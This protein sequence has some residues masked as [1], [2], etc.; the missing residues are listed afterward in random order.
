VINSGATM[1]RRRPR[2]LAVG[3]VILF[4]SAVAG[5]RGAQMSPSATAMCKFADGKTITIEYSSPQVRGRQ[6]FGGLVPYGMPWIL[7]ANQATSFVST[8]GVTMGG[9]RVPAG[10][11]SLFAIPQPDAWALIV[12]KTP[13]ENI[14][15]MSYY[16]GADSDLLRVP[17]TVSALSGVV[18][19]FTISFAPNGTSCEMVF[20]WE[21]TRAG[22]VIQEAP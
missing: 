15:R 22:G 1:V 9:K 18:E 5:L 10:N 19:G 17:L 8:V 20:S 21:R 16:P 4:A 14:G 2:G 3:L 7:G 12:N 11:Y 6:I 13:R